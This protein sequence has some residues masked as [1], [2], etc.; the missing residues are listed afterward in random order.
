[1]A[2]GKTQGAFLAGPVEDFKE[3]QVL[4]GLLLKKN[5]V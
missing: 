5:I 3:I 2:R 1:V 4:W